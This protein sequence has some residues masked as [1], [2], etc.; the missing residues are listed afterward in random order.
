[1][2]KKLLKYLNKNYWY[3]RKISNHHYQAISNI[4]GVVIGFAGKLTWGSFDICMDRCDCFDK[5]SK[6][7]VRLKMPK[8]EKQMKFFFDQAEWL[9]SPS[10][11]KIS[12]GY[13]F[14]NFITEY[15]EEEEN[16]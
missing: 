6:C 3:I 7:P 16:K 14:D 10:G 5:P 4:N 13:D 12:N 1:M 2:V 8:N 15:P 11:Y 9:M